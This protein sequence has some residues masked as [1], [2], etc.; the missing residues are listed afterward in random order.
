VSIN[1]NKEYEV[2]MALGDKM[3][4]NVDGIP[5]DVYPR[6]VTI[7]RTETLRIQVDVED[8]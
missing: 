2:V 4:V 5:V 1:E 6:H 8:K 3:V 7:A